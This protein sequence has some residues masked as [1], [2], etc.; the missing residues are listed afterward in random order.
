MG[1]AYGSKGDKDNK[2]KPP[3]SLLPLAGVEAAARAFQDGLKYG[4]HNYKKGMSAH[5]LADAALRHIF[6]YLSGE[7]ITPDS[8][9]GAPHLGCAIAEL[10]MIEECKRLGTLVD[11]R[12]KPKD[13]NDG[14][15][16]D[17]QASILGRH[18]TSASGR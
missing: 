7:D 5:E 11:D 16:I 6:A 12:F 17:N 2:G 1:S 10:M 9:N 13:S 14:K 15:T 8:E 18:S 4:L 3:I